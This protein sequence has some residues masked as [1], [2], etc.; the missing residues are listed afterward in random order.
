MLRTLP[1]ANKDITTRAQLLELAIEHHCATKP[2]KE[3]NLK[4]L[5]KAESYMKHMKQSARLSRQ[6]L[7]DHKA[8]AINL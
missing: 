8:E 1:Q 2:A 5:T 6:K 4:L 7:A 3:E